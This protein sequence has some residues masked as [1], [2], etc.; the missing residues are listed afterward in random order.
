MRTLTVKLK[1]TYLHNLRENQGA[2]CKHYI[3]NPIK[4]LISCGMPSFGYLTAQEQFT[5][6]GIS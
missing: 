3:A 6:S 2:D 5:L 1:Q 4:A